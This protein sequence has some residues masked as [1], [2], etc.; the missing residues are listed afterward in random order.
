MNNI[1][2]TFYH[3]HAWD[4]QAKKDLN[5]TSII[6]ITKKKKPT[7]NKKQNLVPCL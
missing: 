6:T 2:Y 5:N 4:T 3:T 1:Y 7:Q